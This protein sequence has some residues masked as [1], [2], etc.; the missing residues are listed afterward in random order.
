MRNH[1]WAPDFVS[2]SQIHWMSSGL[3]GAV[4]KAGS[5]T[6]RVLFEAVS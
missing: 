2:N 4:T 6:L 5:G 1:T 3:L